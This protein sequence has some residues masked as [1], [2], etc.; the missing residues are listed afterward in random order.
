MMTWLKRKLSSEKEADSTNTT[1]QSR[2]DILQI[3]LCIPARVILAMIR[4]N[5]MDSDCGLS[6]KINLYMIVYIIK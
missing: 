6:L 2:S 1:K 5:I 4:T 3:L